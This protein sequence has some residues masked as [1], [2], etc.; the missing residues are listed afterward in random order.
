MHSVVKETP[1]PGARFA[2]SPVPKP[3][4]GDILIR[5][6]ATS[7]CGTDLHV[8]NWDEWAQHRV[9]PPRIMGHECAGEVVEL[10]EGARGVKVGDLV[11]IETHVTCG[12]CRACRTGQGHIC[13]AVSI[14]GVDRDGTFADYLTIPAKNAWVDP[15]GMDPALASI[16][17]PFGNAVHTVFSGEVTGLRVAVVG[18][19]PIGSMAVGVLRAAGAAKILATDLSPSRL[20]LARIMGADVLVHAASEDLTLRMREESEGEGFD[21][22]LEMSGSGR[23]LAQAI[24]GLRNGGRVALL[25]LPPREVSL[26]L[27]D[28]I[29]MRGITLQGI[30][31]RRMFEDWYLARSLQESGRLDLLPL[32]THRLP[33]DGVDEAMRLLESGDAGKIVL[34][35]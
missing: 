17:E 4:S 6:L 11:S 28:D 23:A 3:G 2:Q 15:P 24:R 29:I 18:A 20:E 25:G 33:L 31:G 19:G 7:I 12:V 9:R 21:V 22:V 1:G 34:I 14:L 16:Q 10:G 26:N 27:G 35:P 5:V 32:I 13:E 30:T 8:Y